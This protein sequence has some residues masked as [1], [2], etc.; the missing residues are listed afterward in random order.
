[1]DQLLQFRTNG[2]T[3]HYTKTGAGPAIIFIPGSIS[4]YRTWAEVSKQFEES[5]TCI[6]LSRRYL[7]PEKYPAGGDSSV[8]ANTADIAHFI[9]ELNLGP[10]TLVGHSYGGFIALNLAI[11]HP[12]LVEMVVAEEPI[13]VPALLSNPKNPLQLLGLMFRNFKA[14]KDFARLGMKGVDPTFKAL[15]KGDTATA[16]KTFID[17]VTGGKST[18]ETLDDLTR[19]QLQDNIAALAG[20]DPFNN[21][22]SLADAKKIACK[23]LLISGTE[24][25]YTFRYINECLEKT[26][27]EVQHLVV[28]GAAHWIHIDR[29]EAFVQG[30]KS[31]VG[32]KEFATA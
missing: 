27:P 26:I 16:Q 15:A 4:D 19:A 31:F 9:Q 5:H 14:G 24:S 25:I 2:V 23:T 7:F 29:R 30:V 32:V 1:M 28:P 13:F 20:E 10:A 21:N 12:N 6:V 11:T 22:L 17:G 8:A 3:L 18:P